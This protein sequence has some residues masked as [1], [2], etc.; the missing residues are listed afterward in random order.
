MPPG[1]VGPDGAKGAVGQIA[2]STVL[3]VCGIVTYVSLTDTLGT[4]DDLG[5]SVAAIG[6]V[7]VAIAPLTAWSSLVVPGWL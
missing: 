1:H 4:I 7:L 2:W 3:L 6:F 5:A